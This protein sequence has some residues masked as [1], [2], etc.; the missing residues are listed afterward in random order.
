MPAGLTEDSHIY[1]YLEDLLGQEDNDFS[2]EMLT[3]SYG[4][5]QRM[6]L[7]WIQEVTESR[8]KSPTKKEIENW[9]E[10]L[11]P[12]VIVVTIDSAYSHF[13]NTV[14]N[15]VDDLT[16]GIVESVQNSI[17]N[18]EL[19]AL[20]DKYSRLEQKV[21][22]VSPKQVGWNVGASIIASIVMIAIFVVIFQFQDQTDS[23]GVP[24]RAVEKDKDANGETDDEGK[25][26]TPG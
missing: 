8:G 12:N 23:S 25:V 16:P 15:T 5:Y 3:L 22:R 6:K 24:E 14:R 2:P 10:S 18:N 7:D 4:A 17:T 9:I 26:A 11:A 20:N 21:D 19:I 13:R 1:S